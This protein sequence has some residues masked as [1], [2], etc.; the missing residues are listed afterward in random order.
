MKGRAAFTLVEL[1]VVIA[2]IAILAAL[3]LPALSRA[4]Q[5]AQGVICLNNG[6]QIMMAMVI[7]G[8]DF[9]DFF[10]PNP[11]DGNTIPGYNWCGGNASIGG[12]DEFNP[13][14]LKDPSRSLLITYLA[15]QTSLFH[16]PGDRRMGF[17]QGTDPLL[18]GQI[19]PAARTFSM[20]Q[21]VGT[22][23]PGFDASEF[24]G[25]GY[26][27]SGSP[28]VS[29]NGPW[30]NNQHTHRR[31]SPWYTYGKFSDLRAPGP[32]M[33]WILLD[34]DPVNL[35]DAAFAFGMESAQWFDVPGTYHNS[36]CGFAFGDGHSEYHKW[37]LG[38]EKQGNGFVIT[39]PSDQQDWMWMHDRTSADSTGTM[40]PPTL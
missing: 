30:L 17:Y 15:G 27:H 20:S 9:T 34:E 35:N 28:N 25:D 13:D 6:K 12:P 14:V 19:I 39:N 4:K 8:N 2:I 38:A 11:D 33:T 23:D 32:S 29:V 16:C 24:T 10:P 18:I 1:L 3:L 31:N 37:K 5:R 36:G 7:Y 40:P 22:I 21:A 26:V